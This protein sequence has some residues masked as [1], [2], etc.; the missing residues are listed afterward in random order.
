V[1]TANRLLYELFY[2]FPQTN[3]WDA[4]CGARFDLASNSLRPDG[5]TSADAAGLP[6]FPG[7]V[8]YE[9]VYIKGEINHAIRFTV[10]LSQRAYIYP[11]T[12]FASSSTDPNRPP[13]G[14][15][16]RLKAGYDISGFSPP[17]QVIL[18]A[19]KKYGIMMAD[20]GSNWYISGAPDDRWDDD[21]L[22]E[23]RNV[24]GADF[25]A[26]QTVDANG[27]PILPGIRDRISFAPVRMVQPT[28]YPF[29]MNRLAG[30]GFSPV[31]DGRTGPV[32]DALGRY[33]RPV[34]EG[35]GFTKT[36]STHPTCR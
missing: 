10:S 30:I 31:E 22:Q 36:P 16:F 17:I 1:D 25:E 5:W 28:P 6:I 21:V 18:R 3:R 4:S 23:L 9:D 35:S 34:G 14:L 12:H 7:L 32:F 29:L 2:A 26:V 8:R 24:T 20:N 11:A 27:D 33:L 15:R 19:F 13:M